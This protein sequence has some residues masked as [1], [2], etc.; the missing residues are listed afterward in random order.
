MKMTKKAKRR[1]EEQLSY[2]KDMHMHYWVRGNDVL[3]Q[4]YYGAYM[5]AIA[6]AEVMG[7]ITENE[8]NEYRE[9]LNK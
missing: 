3:Q 9:K 7:L 1:F 4:E 6:V 2:Y 8:A 5:G